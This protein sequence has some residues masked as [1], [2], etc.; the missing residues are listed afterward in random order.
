MP[1]IDPD[2]HSSSSSGR[3]KPGAPIE[4]IPVQSKSKLYTALAIGVT[5]IIILLAFAI[6][7][8]K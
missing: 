3:R 8:G 7:I 4:D 5:V 1:N 6:T 2:S